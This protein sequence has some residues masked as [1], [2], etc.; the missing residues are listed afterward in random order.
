MV[1]EQ[2]IVCNISWLGGAFVKTV[3]V[4]TEEQ[5]ERIQQLVEYMYKEIFPQYFTAE[6]IYE[7]RLLNFLNV[8]EQNPR[9]ETLTESYQIIASLETIILMIESGVLDQEKYQ[10]LFV[11][12]AEQLSKIGYDFP[13]SYTS[14]LNKLWANNSQSTYHKISNQWFIQ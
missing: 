3:Y 14:F 11:H 6:E 13:F 9:D 5:V 4:Q 10:H 2:D 8:K 1:K 12:N 7:F